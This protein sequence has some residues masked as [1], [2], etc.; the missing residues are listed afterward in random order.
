MLS[1]GKGTDG[2]TIF[3]LSNQSQSITGDGTY[4]VLFPESHSHRGFSPVD[5]GE[6]LAFR[7][8]F[9]GDYILGESISE[10]ESASHALA[11]SRLRRPM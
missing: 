5:Q 8:R 3:L 10:L 11:A 2:L 4:A 6:L 7:N 9:N 1:A